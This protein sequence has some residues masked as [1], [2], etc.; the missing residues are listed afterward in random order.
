MRT[1]RRRLALVVPAAAALAACQP[2]QLGTF[3]PR[4]VD[5]TYVYTDCDIVEQAQA[6]DVGIQRVQQ[7][8]D[9]TGLNSTVRTLHDA[10]IE[11]QLT[12]KANPGVSGALLPDD[13]RVPGDENAARGT[14][15]TEYRGQL[16]RRLDEYRA[17]TG[18]SAPMIAI[19]NEANH[20][21]FYAGTAAD[22][23]TELRIAVD[24]AHRRGVE[25]TDSGIGTKAVKLVV[26]NHLRT[27]AGSAKAD[28]YLRTVFRSTSDSNDT[29]LRD[30]LLGAAIDDPDPYA[31]VN[32]T[33]R[34][35]WQDAETML[36]A[37][38]TG[39][40]D[41]RLDAVNFHWYT[42][43]EPNPTTYSD[44]RALTDTIDA[45]R[46]ITGLPVVTNEIGQHGTDPEAVS[47][48]LEVTVRERDLALVIWF[49][50]D[51]TP[52]HGL[53]HPTDPGRLRASGRTFRNY[54]DEIPYPP[55]ACGRR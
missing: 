10:G 46:A 40:G 44:R 53:F 47:T 49:D 35:N 19:E 15:V 34:G 43:D 42:P 24:V 1:L 36:A 48:S 54:T 5:E 11:A 14:T 3:L 18:A 22:Y 8:V 26:W 17:L 29:I 30:Q 4:A 32:P 52:A 39:P 9:T 12:F 7:V 45:L 25:I 28:R 21:Q 41:L 13:P 20:G 51:G 33:I 38:G 2:H 27:T 31:R 55:S 16:G 6:L 23:L 50:A 37:Y